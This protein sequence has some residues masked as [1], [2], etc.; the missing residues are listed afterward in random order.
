L[1][2][3]GIV[4][5]ERQS[6]YDPEQ[7]TEPIGVRTFALASLLGTVSVLAAPMSPALPWIIG[8]GYL[9]LVLAFLFF[10]AQEREGKPGITTQISALLVYAVG[11]LVPSEPVLAAVSG[12]IV[13]GVL[14]VKE[15]THRLVENLTDEEVEGT[16]KFLLISVVVLPILPTKPVDPWGI[17]HPQEIWFLV[18]LISGISFI[19]YFAIRFFG[20]DRGIAL[21]G[22]LGGL[23]SSTAVTLSMCHRVRASVE[24]DRPIHR[25]AAF[26]ILVASGIMTV[27]VAV[28]VMAVDLALG[29]TL[30]APLAALAVPGGIV[31]AIF[32]RRINDDEL[33]E[34]DDPESDSGADALDIT[35][36]FQLTPALKFGGIFVVI[37]GVVYLARQ[38]F[39][40]SGA[41]VASFLSGLVNMD[42]VSVAVAR[43]V[44]AQSVVLETAVNA[45]IIG[46][47]A[48]SMSKAV[49]SWLFGSRR[50]GLYVAGGLIPTVAVGIAVIFLL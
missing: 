25:A 1:A 50:L 49:M 26:A 15:W 17:Y 28:L 10:E 40:Q 24:D 43:M 38:L 9:A 29:T 5:L 31:A 3:G 20:R 2:L 30:L 13:V 27:R 35:N 36:P 16:V 33:V 42:A 48:N 44:E 22:A 37:I 18:V 6:H 45:V 8:L 21:T 14:S 47:L 34:V 41:Y 32:W 19:G 7:G 4:G 12:V 23:A 39:G 11:V 46:V